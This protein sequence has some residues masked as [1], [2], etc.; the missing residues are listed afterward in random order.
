[1]Q[2][3]TESLKAN[4]TTKTQT[5]AYDGEQHCAPNNTSESHTIKLQSG[6]EIVV[7]WSWLV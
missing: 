2:L 5:Q 6:T 7:K 1:M 4:L 3:N